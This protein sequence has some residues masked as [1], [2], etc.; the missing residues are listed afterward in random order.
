[1]EQRTKPSYKKIIIAL[2]CVLA[3]VYVIYHIAQSLRHDV[4]LFAVRPDTADDVQTFTGYLFRDETVL[5]SAS[6]GIVNYRYSSG[7]KVSSG[8]VV[9]DVYAFGNEDTVEKIAD[10][11]N[12]ISVLKRSTSISGTTVGQVQKQIDTLSARISELNASGNLSAASTLANELLAAMAKKDL[13]TS[14]RSN[15]NNEIA[16]LEAQ[17]NVLA[18]SLGT[19]SASIS[20]SSSGYF[21]SGTDG[22]EGAFTLAAAQAITFESFDRLASMSPSIASNAIGTLMTDFHWYY[23][24]KTTTGSAEG[25]T[26]GNTY[27]C[28]FP[29]NSYTESIRM[30]LVSKQTDE[31][32]NALLTFSSSS[33]PAAFD[34]TRCQ[35]MEAVRTTYSGYRIPAGE[36]RVIDGATFVYIYDEGSARLREVDI[37]WEENGY[38]LV[39]DSYESPS[40][41]PVLALNDLIIVGEKDLYDG[42]IIN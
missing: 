30:Q 19:P 39:S 3:A 10:L 1:M 31:S 7:E 14:G 29:D 20:V 32:G 33:L 25:F 35:R 16:A 38:Y 18:A 13:L 23:V 22:Y 6:S 15:Y 5:T 27:N 42:K 9:A 4:E 11:Q 21:Y 34:M 28:R 24:C 41:N 36:V 37:I 8:S 26:V 40:E 2:L 12:Q 17:K